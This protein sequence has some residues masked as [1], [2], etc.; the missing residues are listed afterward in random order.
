MT[1][2]CELHTHLYGCLQLDDLR[3]LA[4]RR[5]PR[6]QIFVESYRRSYGRDPDISAMFAQSAEGQRRLAEAAL[7]RDAGDFARFQTCFDLV[8]ALSHTDA[9]ELREVAARVVSR[10]PEAYAEYRMLFSPREDAVSFSEKVHALAEGLA[11]VSAPGREARLAV[12]L[13]RQ[14]DLCTARY[15]DVRQLMKRSAVAAQC[16][17]AIDFC[18][19]EEGHPPTPM[20]PFFQRVRADNAAAPDQALAIL[21]HVG[22]SFTDKSVESAARWILQAAEAGAHRLGHCI[23]AGVDPEFYRGARRMER[24]DERLDQIDFEIEHAAALE[25]AGVA[26]DAAALREERRKLV[27]RP[28][29]SRVEQIYDA[30]RVQRLRLYQ[31]W[32]LSRL[33]QSSVVVESCPTS[34]LRI[35]ALQDSRFHP[36]PRF[37]SAGVKTVLGADD[38]GILDISLESEFALVQNWPGVTDSDVQGMRAVAWQSRSPAMLRPMK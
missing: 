21:Y 36:L 25:A 2:L 11:A 26:V 23:A 38:P 32:L 15:Q 16:I 24:V 5:A 7:F 34:N 18:H 37:L 1:A 4:S 22:E 20:A 13:P 3:W 10:Q 29:D 9:E 6:W 12:S 30:A 14:I 31:D 33:A 17:V 35:A 28:D 8:I 27:E 19:V